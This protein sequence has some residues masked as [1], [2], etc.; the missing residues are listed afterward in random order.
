MPLDHF[1]VGKDKV[2][3][4]SSPRWLWLNITLVRVDPLPSTNT[5]KN[6]GYQV[7]CNSK[8]QR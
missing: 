6:Y 3:K 8:L 5:V 7:F 4:Y 1:T 2:G